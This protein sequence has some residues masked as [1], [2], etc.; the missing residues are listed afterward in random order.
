METLEVVMTDAP[1]TPDTAPSI[2]LSDAD[3]ASLADSRGAQGPD[4]VPDTLEVRNDSI[5]V[6]QNSMA[7]FRRPV[8]IAVTV[9]GAALA[10]LVG[11]GFLRRLGQGDVTPPG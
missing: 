11:A 5:A 2:F 1:S 6:M 9:V 7:N 4:A 3:E 8:V 10:L